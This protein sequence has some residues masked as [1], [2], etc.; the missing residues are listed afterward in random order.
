MSDWVKPFPPC[1]CGWRG[2]GTS[3]DSKMAAAATYTL[4]R[5]PWPFSHLPQRENDEK[6]KRATSR[7]GK[8][9]H[10]TVRPKALPL[11]KLLLVSGY[12]Y[13]NLQDDP[14]M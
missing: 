12:N 6:G 11:R 10:R 4:R 5:H 1:E 13:W 7:I 14:A 3:S 9:P 8:L 2:G